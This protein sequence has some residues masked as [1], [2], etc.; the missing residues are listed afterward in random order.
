MLGECEDGMDPVQDELPPMVVASPICRG[1]GP[2][3]KYQAGRDPTT[4]N[5][6]GTTSTSYPDK[7]WSSPARGSGGDTVVV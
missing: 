7:R 2:L 3:P 6:K 4:G 1:P 5:I